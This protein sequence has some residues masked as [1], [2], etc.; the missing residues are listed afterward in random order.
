MYVLIFFPL[1]VAYYLT[2][3][4]NSS[5]SKKINLLAAGF[6]SVCL[7]F[8][9]FR[10]QANILFLPAYLFMLYSI[11]VGMIRFNRNEIEI[12]KRKSTSAHAVLRKAAKLLFICFSGFII[13]LFPP[14]HLP[15][16]TG[17]YDI[18]VIELYFTDVSREE[19]YTQD[20]TDSRELMAQIWYPTDRKASGTYVSYP[21]EVGSAVNAVL[22]LPELLFSYFSTIKTHTV[23]NPM[24]SQEESLYPLILFS[25]GNRSTRFQNMA[26]VEDLVSNGYIVVGV[27]H[28]YTSNDVR[29][30]DGSVAYR[31]EKRENSLLNVSFFEDE[32]D[33]R[34][35]D[36][37]FILDQLQSEQLTTVPDEVVAHIDFAR[38]GFVG[39]SYGGA[40]VIETLAVDSRVVAG[41]SL[42]GG[43]WGT[44]PQQGIEQP[45]LYMNASETL[46]Y[47]WS[48]AEEMQAHKQFVSTVIENLALTQEKSNNDFY[49]MI[50]QDYNHYSFTD[51]PLISPLLKRGKEPVITTNTIVKTFFDVYIKNQTDAN[52][53]DIAN[54]YE[55]I[56]FQQGPQIN[57][58]GIP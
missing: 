17:P 6:I 45:F 52:L 11:V 4:K 39:H 23:S 35:K 56:E 51:I 34:T 24:I 33:I 18:G 5:S 22:H 31:S 9:I 12:D 20:A 36:I 47:L 28:P 37:L 15:Q 2:E 57:F 26:L 30:A 27:D 48:D 58:P 54:Q 49:Y 8:F 21:Q 14:F 7:I 42:D 32:I 43:V 25:P 10:Y 41:V 29:F 3:N 38:I 50:F 53:A 1:F 13:I 55:Y 46:A 19:S 44:A 40:T 16:P